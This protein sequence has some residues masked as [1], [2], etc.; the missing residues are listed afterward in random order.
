MAYK[1]LRLFFLISV[2]CV[3]TGCGLVKPHAVTPQQSKTGAGLVAVLPV[4]NKAG[5]ERAG[6]ILRQKVFYELYFKGYPKIP[7]DIIDEKLSKIYKENIGPKKESV[8]PQVVG[9]LLNIDAVMYCTLNEG[10]TSFFYFR[11]S[12]VISV[13]LELKSTKTGETI[14]RARYRTVKRSYGFSRRDLEMKSCQVYEPA[15]RE[16][17]NKAMKTLP[18]GP[19]SLG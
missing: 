11:A 4:N 2:L 1:F 5:D 7:F 8:S 9:E 17:V 19:D 10:K 12:T 16:I 18:D 3:G 15:I 13:D 14:W 6:Q